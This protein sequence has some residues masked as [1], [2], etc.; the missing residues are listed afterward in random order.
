MIDNDTVDTPEERRNVDLLRGAYGA[1][2][3]GNPQPFFDLCAVDVRFGIAAAPEHFTFAGVRAGKDWVLHVIGQIAKEFEWLEF[4]P[5]ELIAER[6]W[7]IALTGGKIRD[8]ETGAILDAELVDVIR[9]QNGQI[10]YFV[11]YFDAS[12]LYR[13]HSARARLLEATG[14]APS[15]KAVKRKAPAHAKPKAKPKAKR[16]A[17]KPKAKAA[18]KPK[19]KAAAKTK[20]KPAP[21]RSVVRKTG[22]AK[23]PKNRRR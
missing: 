18:A 6:D 13:R 1:Y 8:R 4:E 11:E 22:R 5:R 2:K 7:V 19:A 3:Q 23:T 14:R 16:A 21:R 12:L 10:A 20:A 15:G 17:A 9:M